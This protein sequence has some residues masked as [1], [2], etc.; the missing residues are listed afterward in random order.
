MILDTVQVLKVVDSGDGGAS[1]DL[2]IESVKADVT[3]PEWTA[4]YDSALPEDDK[5]RENNA[6]MAFKPLVG[7][8]MTLT[9]DAQGNITSVSGNQDSQGRGALAPTVQ[10][11]T[12]TD[13]VRILW[14]TILHAKKG[15]GTFKVGDT[16]TNEESFVAKPLGAT[17]ETI[18][19]NTLRG[20]ANGVASL[21]TAG[22]MRLVP[23]DPAVPSRFDLKN[24]KLTA[25][26]GWSATDGFCESMDLSRTF[27]LEGSVQGIPL[28][29]R[30]DIRTTVTRAK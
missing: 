28:V 8:K 4:A 12:G 7:L 17:F 13:N 10:Q 23:L 24:A 14:N 11:L 6:L 9:T 25:T 15:G 2:T 22:E 30:S 18:A 1:M 19:T 5:D 3:M 20:V 16:W 29:R 27:K 26:S 21:D